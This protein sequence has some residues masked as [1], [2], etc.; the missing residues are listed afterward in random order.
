MI[1]GGISPHQ[2]VKCNAPVSTSG[3]RCPFCGTEQ[4]TVGPTQG[5]QA[6]T[7]G[8]SDLN[9]ARMGLQPQAPKAR[10]SM[11]PAALVVVGVLAGFVMLAAT[12]FLLMHGEAAST[13]SVASAAVA[14][15][16][17]PVPKTQGS[18]G[19][20]ALRNP[21]KV[22]VT[23]PLPQIRRRLASWDPD[24]QLLDIT[25]THAHGA[26][27][28]LGQDGP[29]VVYRFASS[30]R[31][32]RVA[33]GQEKREGMQ[34]TLRHGAPEPEAFT[35]AASEKAA[36]EPNC[37]WSAAYRM[38]VN[39]GLPAGGPLDARYGPTGKGTETTWVFTSPDQQGATRE[40]DGMT[41][42]VKTH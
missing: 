42:A 1:E 13:P 41:C 28:D 7:V 25:V 18:V 12:M 24:P 10:P 4:P 5:F 40:L 35:V 30:R 17:P 37:V 14:S 11:Q 15:A 8:L 2:C 36:P 6:A 26:L 20:I 23:D 19:G 22:D 33:R 3:G 9:R 34:V 21:A 39:A 38:A 29:A 32:P 31:D 16:A 27:I